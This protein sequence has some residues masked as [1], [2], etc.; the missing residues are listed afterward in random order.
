MLTPLGLRLPEIL[1]GPRD[2]ARTVRVL[3]EPGIGTVVPDLLV[4]AWSRGQPPRS[5]ASLTLIDAYVRALLERHGP[6][7]G[8]AVRARLHLSPGSWSAAAERLR[9]HGVLVEA[10]GPFHTSTLAASATSHRLEITAIEAKLA[11]WRDAIAQAERYLTFANRAI[12]VLDGQRVAVTSA[13]L[14]AARTAGVGLMLQGRA[15][16]DVVLEAPWQMTPVTPWRVLAL[17]KLVTERGTRAI[18]RRP[19]RQRALAEVGG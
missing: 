18:R 16:L 4:G 14:D 5:Y 8:D 15:D 2:G 9:R 11:R 7:T 12:V 13:L 3:R 10:S 1:Y 6:L 19:P 17:T